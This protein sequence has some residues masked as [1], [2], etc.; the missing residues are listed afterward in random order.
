MSA[1]SPVGPIHPL[2]LALLDWT[3][4]ARLGSLWTSLAL[5]DLRDRYSRTALGLLWIVVSF[6]LFVA[7]KI[8]VF[9]QLA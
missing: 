2:K 1:T 9:G 6:A 7:V 5:E 8:V 4:A 3:R